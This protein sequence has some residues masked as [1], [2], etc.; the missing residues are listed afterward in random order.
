V[1]GAEGSSAPAEVSAAAAAGWR[2]AAAGGGQEKPCCRRPR[3]LLPARPPPAPRHAA[4]RGAA[5]PPARAARGGRRRARCHLPRNFGVRWARALHRPLVKSEA[6]AARRPAGS[7]AP[8]GARPGWAPCLM[9]RPPPR[10]TQIPYQA[11]SAP[12]AGAA[13]ASANHASLTLHAP[14][15]CQAAASAPASHCW[16]AAGRPCFTH[17]PRAA[18]A[19]TP[20]WEPPTAWPALCTRCCIAGEAGRR[21][22]PATH[23]SC[24]RGPGPACYYLPSPLDYPPSC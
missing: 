4:W 21:L 10:P 24:P 23:G 14:R 19:G 6:R 12:A 17:G 2:Q 16:I 3:C 7:A 15:T 13:V 22:L 1:A 8:P 5:Q 18:A 9:R 20:T 11:P